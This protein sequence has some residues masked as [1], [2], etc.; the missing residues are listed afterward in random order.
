M[1]HPL[2]KINNEEV[3]N[4]IGFSTSRQEFESLPGAKLSGIDQNKFIQ[5][6]QVY[7]VK[8]L[9]ADKG[10]GFACLI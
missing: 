3:L 10:K 7:P 5:G 4:T 9:I 8:N 1:S 2:G 6:Q